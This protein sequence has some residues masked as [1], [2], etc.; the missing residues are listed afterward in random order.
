[1]VVNIMS[2]FLVP[3]DARTRT[4]WPMFHEP[5][6]KRPF[7]GGKGSAQAAQLRGCALSPSA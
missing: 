7:S 6:G 1:M 2:S 5:C 3:I 4:G